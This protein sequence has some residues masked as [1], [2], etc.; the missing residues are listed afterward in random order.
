MEML[1][2][3]SAASGS[4]KPTIMADAAYAVLSRDSGNFTG[5]FCIDD[6]V[7]KEV[8]VTNFDQYA[9]DPSELRSL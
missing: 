5:N 2:G 3:D 6:D 1:A 4:R 9:I 8:G 7:L